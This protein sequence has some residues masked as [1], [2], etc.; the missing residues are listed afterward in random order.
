LLNRLLLHLLLL[1]HLFLLGGVHWLLRHML[2]GR[3]SVLLLL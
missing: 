1:L 2:L 3:C